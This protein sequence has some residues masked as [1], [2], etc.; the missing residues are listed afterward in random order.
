[1]ERLLECIKLEQL[2]LA[3]DLLLAAL[4]GF[5]IGLERKLRDK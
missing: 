5:F 3:F 2:W 4:L 1:M